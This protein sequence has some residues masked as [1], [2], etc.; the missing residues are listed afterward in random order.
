MVLQTFKSW[1]QVF[2]NLRGN[3][4]LQ[5]S[6]L[7]LDLEQLAIGRL[8]SGPDYDYR[9][10]GG[11]L[12]PPDWH[13]WNNVR[14]RARHHRHIFGNSKVD[15]DEDD[16]CAQY[17]TKAIW[18]LE[19]TYGTDGHI[20]LT[21]I[22]STFQSL[23][24]DSRRSCDTS[25]VVSYSTQMSHRPRQQAIRVE[26]PHC[27][28]QRRAKRHTTR[29][30]SGRPTGSSSQHSAGSQTGSEQ[31]AGQSVVERTTIS[32]GDSSVTPAT[33]WAS[34]WSARREDPYDDCDCIVQ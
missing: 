16:R 33:A 25:S 1:R 22:D 15:F 7:V 6:R 11:V 3:E 17:L 20:S 27:I 30:E 26:A 18:G 21:E 2:A 28:R 13:I 10:H 8:H 24:A 23:G 31:F 12:D 19:G 14:E 5:F 9:Q 32:Q 34:T 4:E 29:R